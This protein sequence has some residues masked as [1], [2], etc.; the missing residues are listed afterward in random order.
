[1]TN[2]NIQFTGQTKEKV[3]AEGIFK[4]IR[5]MTFKSLQ[6]YFNDNPKE[7]KK[8]TDRIKANAKA[9]IE[10]TKI[11]NAVIKGE[12]NNFNEFMMGNFEP[13]NNRGRNDYRELLIIEG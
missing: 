6:T 4:P 10:S 1:M 7:L 3:S 9:R 12:T 13:A 2:Y 8:I 11:R 5:D